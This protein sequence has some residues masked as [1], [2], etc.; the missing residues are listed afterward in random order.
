MLVV[1]NSAANYGLDSVGIRVEVNIASRGFPGFD[2]VGLPSKAV[3]ESKERVKTAIINSGFDFPN[4]K[5]TVNLA[6]ADRPK[7]G[8]SFDLPI[9][10]GILIAS[11]ETNIG[12]KLPG[13]FLERSLFFGELSL[14]G[15]LRHTKGVLLAAL[16]TQEIK[17]TNLFIPALNYN[18]AGVIKDLSV[19]PV[20]DLKSLIDNFSDMES[21]QTSRK[22]D[23]SLQQ[24]KEAEDKSEDDFADVIGQEAAKRAL[25]IAAAGGHSLLMTGPPG[26]GKTLL[27]KALPSI[28][29]PLNFE[30]SL[31]VTKIYSAAGLLEEGSSLMKNRPV[32]GP[33]HTTSFAGIIGGG[34]PPKVGEISLAHRGVLF[35]DEFPEFSRRVMESLR[36]PL[37]DGKIKIIRSQSRVTFPSKFILIAAANPCPCGYYGSQVRTCNCTQ[38]QI[39]RYK[40]KISGPIKDR[41]DMHVRMDVLSTKKISRSY[42]NKR[43]SRKSREIKRE[44]IGARKIQEK[45]YFNLAI[46]TNSEINTR[47]MGKYCII[48]SRAQSILD[49]ASE[50]FGLTTR[51]YFKLIRVAQTIADLKS[52]KTITEADIAEAIQYRTETSFQV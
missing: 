50:K 26:G 22:A 43:L 49:L 34:N 8:S 41:I 28:L 42:N 23:I 29:P 25:V 6:P 36:Q 7:E 18:E 10:I 13:D 39:M 24:R 37:E 40:N 4:K 2:I 38:Y 48:D 30:E 14:D 21:L 15:S 32:R 17:M 12:S 52:Q 19:Y 27:A 44:V 47:Q 3:A 1:I 16:F 9:A 20:K 35:M 45:R 11:D 31:E 46:N 33:H 51:V 5:I